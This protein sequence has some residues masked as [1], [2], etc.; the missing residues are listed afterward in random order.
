M[1]DYLRKYI[2]VRDN[3]RLEIVKKSL[4][5]SNDELIKL[6]EIYDIEKIN[7]T[8]VGNSIATGYSMS[9]C[10][11][12]LLLRNDDLLSKLNGRI[13]IYSFAR[14]QDNNDEHIYNWL[15]SNKRQSEINR[16]V[17]LDFTSEKGMPHDTIT[18]DLVKEYYSFSDIGFN[19]LVCLD[20]SNLANILVYNGVTG[21]FL[22]NITRGGKKDLNGFN[23]DLISLEAILKYIYLKAPNTQVYVCGVPNI[24]K[25]NIV[26]FINRKIKE[27]CA[28]YSNAVYVSPVPQSIIYKRD[29]KIVLDVHYNEEEYLKLNTSIISSI[30]ENY[31]F[32]RI[33]TEIDLL[34]KEYSS[35]SHYGVSSINVNDVI[36]QVLS[37]KKLS[38]NE[39]KRIE[40]YYKEKYPYDYF[41]T[42]KDEI[43]DLI[44]EGSVK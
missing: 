30:V 42:K 28:H 33:L 22:D 40:K 5:Q 4:E 18:D 21:S 17:E 14:A 2:L 26:G 32:V 16:L 31:G 27:I 41:Y 34:L 9:D 23:R 11:K 37:S 38:F 1:L 7:L 43:S 39:L 29:G 25:I 24:A 8:S 20:S 44:R 35:D 36:G 13:S 3:K 6:L 15:I 12:P 19:D 10:I